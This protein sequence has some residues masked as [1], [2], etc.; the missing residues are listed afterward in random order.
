MNSDYEFI[1]Y[2]CTL[3]HKY[4]SPKL[5][6][7]C[8]SC[9]VILLLKVNSCVSKLI[10]ILYTDLTK[11]LHISKFIHN[12]STL[13]LYVSYLKFLNNII[14]FVTV[15]HIQSFMQRSLR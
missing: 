12:Y 6:I 11:Y 3:Y 7:T 15:F 5:S 4:L 1:I 14:C 13:I 8:I 10:Y 2:I 9:I